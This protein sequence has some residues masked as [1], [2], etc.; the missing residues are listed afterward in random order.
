MKTDCDS[1]AYVGLLVFLL[2]APHP[3]ENW[4]A[5]AGSLVEGMQVSR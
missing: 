3:I 5:A 2:P 4:G 1:F